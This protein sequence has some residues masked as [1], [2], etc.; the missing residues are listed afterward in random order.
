[1][2]GRESYGSIEQDSVAIM[3]SDKKLT[4]GRGPPASSPLVAKCTDDDT[5]SSTNVYQLFRDDGTG[6]RNDRDQLGWILIRQLSV[7]CVVCNAGPRLASLYQHWRCITDQR[8]PPYSFDGDTGELVLDENLSYPVH[9]STIRV[10]GI[11]LC[12][13][14]SYLQ[15][16]N[17]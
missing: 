5:A 17:K 12:V 11:Y 14:L 16:S 6:H 4:T 3:E 8:P 2:D 9:K 1:M 7:A 10:P 15:A 13:L